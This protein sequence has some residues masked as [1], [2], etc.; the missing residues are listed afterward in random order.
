[1]VNKRFSEFV[2]LHSEVHC[3]GWLPANSRQLQ[4]RFP[5]IR[6]PKLPPKV[7]FGSMSK[8][9]VE[10][11]KQSLQDYMDDLLHRPEISACEDMQS[12][13]AAKQNVGSGSLRVA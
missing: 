4:K 1:M 13:L 10:S 8:S 9:V 3:A 6:L 2:L 12:F 7:W 5:S 11:R